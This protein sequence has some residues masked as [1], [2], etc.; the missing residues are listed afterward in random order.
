MHSGFSNFI[1]EAEANWLRDRWSVGL[2]ATLRLFRND[3]QPSPGSQLLDFQECNWPEYSPVLLLNQ[4][5]P[6]TLSTV[7]NYS[8]SSPIFIFIPP[9]GG[10][11]NNVYGAFIRKENNV[12]AFQRFNEP[13]A[14]VPGAT[15]FKIRL[16]ASTKSG[17]L[18][19]HS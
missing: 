12:E 4:L 16:I 3:F 18:F 13:I 14:M 7:G 10:V 1:L 19:T 11:G 17:S 8:C 15:P 5:G 2:G 6:V 9:A